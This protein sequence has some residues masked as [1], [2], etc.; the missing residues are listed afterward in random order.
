MAGINE[1]KIKVSDF[2]NVSF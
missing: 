1:V 2:L